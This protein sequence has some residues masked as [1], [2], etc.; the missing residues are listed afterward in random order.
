ME[1]YFGLFWFVA[2]VISKTANLQT[3]CFRCFGVK[4]LCFFL[5]FC[6]W[7]HVCV[8]TLI[9]SAVWLKI[10]FCGVRANCFVLGFIFKINMGGL[11]YYAFYH[12][13]K[14]KT[15][16][17]RDI[18]QDSDLV[19]VWI[20]VHRTCAT[21]KRKTVCPLCS[22]LAGGESGSGNITPNILSYMLSNTIISTK[23]ML[24][25]LG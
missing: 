16:A 13:Q 25:S 2:D 1:W 19:K 4:S 14:K 11:C 17:A 10:A 20:I 22:N 12:T 7:Q 23:T 15:Q 9:H 21:L 24:I 8:N 18:T 3:Q 6:W 5:P